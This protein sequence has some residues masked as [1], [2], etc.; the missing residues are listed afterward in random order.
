ML[1]GVSTMATALDLLFVAVFSLGSFS[2]LTLALFLSLMVYAGV[3]Q[4]ILNHM[5]QTNVLTTERM[6]E[7][8]YRIAR[9][10]EA[11]PHRLTEHFS[12]LM[13]ELYDPIEVVP[14]MRPLTRCQRSRCWL[15]ADRARAHRRSRSRP[16]GSLRCAMPTVASGCS[17]P[18]MPAHRPH[19]RATGTRRRF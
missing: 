15:D 16:R 7:Q 2:A 9:D 14:M 18:K 10:V 3:R 6:F 12:S 11:H 19:R 1:A 5:L 4:W 17:H 8:L 13:R